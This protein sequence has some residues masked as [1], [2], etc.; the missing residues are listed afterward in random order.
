[1]KIIGRCIVTGLAI[2]VSVAASAQQGGTTGTPADVKYCNALARS[3]QTMW[4]PNEGMPVGDVVALSQCD[5][6][7][8][9]TIAVLE[10]KLADMK[11]ELPAHEGVAQPA[12][13]TGSTR[14]T[15]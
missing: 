1:M 12:G 10:K 9:A 4:P 6:A 8:A 7:T 11:I 3:Y 2:G 5:S 13:S 14:N 15:Q